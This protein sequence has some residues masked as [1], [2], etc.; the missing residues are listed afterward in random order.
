MASENFK[1]NLITGLA[2][3]VGATLLAPV[4][5]RLIRPATKAAIKGSVLL[6]EKGRESFAELS[7]TVDDL[8][9]EVKSE[10]ETGP[11]GGAAIAASATQAAGAQGKTG[12]PS[13]QPQSD[14][15]T[16][17]NS[18]TKAAVQPSDAIKMSQSP[19][20]PT[21]AQASEGQRDEGAQGRPPT[22]GE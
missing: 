3:G 4:L 2:A 15:D 17:Q 22:K 12:T 11:A 20:A 6:Y 10:M 8:V 7:E 13:A 9:A 1:S 18:A 5:L 21:R 16:R 14:P 19:P